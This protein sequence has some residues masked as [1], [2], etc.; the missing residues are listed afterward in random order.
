MSQFFKSSQ[1]FLGVL[2]VVAILIIGG[3]ILFN[4][5]DQ[6][7]VTEEATSQSE[8][9]EQKQSE[10]E[11][12]KKKIEE[13]SPEEKGDLEKQLNE[14][15]T[16]LSK[17]RKDLTTSLQNEIKDLTE[18]VQNAT[19]EERKELEKQIAEKQK[20][21]GT[22]QDQKTTDESGLP[23]EYS[24]V[25][26]DHLWGIATRFYNDGYKWTVLAAENSIQNPD[27]IIPGQ[28]ITI[29][30]VRDRSYVV[31]K[32]DT[33]WGI[34]EKF[35]GTGFS[36]TSIRNANPGKIGTLPNGNPL[37]VPGQVL[38]IP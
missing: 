15:Q 19:A 33:L 35:Y 37:I 22:L 21:L 11:D 18:K 1:S 16:E 34:S 13:A 4:N 20:E 7:V 2:I 5:R 32:G 30:E 17:L 25:K 14:K 24:V 36:W 10:V 12:L 8:Q 23:T 38:K 29:P 3:V 9:E 28:K 6:G 31:V 27:L 26:G